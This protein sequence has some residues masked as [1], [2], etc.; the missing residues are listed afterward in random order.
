M[1]P[2]GGFFELE[3]GRPGPPLHAGALALCSGRACLRRILEE[4]RPRRALVPFYICASALVPFDTL[5]VPYSFYGLTSSLE[6]DLPTGAADQACLLYVNYFDLKSDCARRLV[7]R[8]GGRVIVDDTQAFFRRGYEN[9]WSF[10]SARKFFGVPD[11]GYAYGPGLGAGPVCPRIEDVR[12]DHLVNRLMGRQEIAYQQYLASEAVVSVE[13]HGPSL[14]AERLLANVDYD[15]AK[16]ARRRNFAFVH[17][18]LGP[19]NRLSVAA[20]GLV[21]AVPF[22]YPFMPD[23]PVT[24]EELWS[25]HVFVPQLWPEVIVRDGQGFDWER[26]VARRLLPL[27][28]DHRYAA[29]D[30]ERVCHEVSGVLA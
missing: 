21:D 15:T 16:Q 24:R 28:I 22:C 14:L 26:D 5:G 23:R 25:R 17:E 9:G 3:V 18:R 1:K 19:L 11:G 20:D 29:D 6:P 12:Y 10:N 2:I 4:M 7:A 13:V 8:G 30:M 27:P